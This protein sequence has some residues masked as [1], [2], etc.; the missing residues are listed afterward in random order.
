MQADARVTR[1]I[2]LEDL[3]AAIRRTI[4]DDDEFKFAE[5]LTENAVER[6]SEVPFSVVDRKE[7]GYGR[8]HPG[9]ILGETVAGVLGAMNVPRLDAVGTPEQ[10]IHHRRAIG[11][12]RASPLDHANHV[13]CEALAM[14]VEFPDRLR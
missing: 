6:L 3:H 13:V 12:V 9:H 7:N 11:C 5:G 8:R 10:M 14:V 1:G 4:V 2:S